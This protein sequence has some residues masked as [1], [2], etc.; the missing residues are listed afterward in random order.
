MKIEFENDKEKECFKHILFDWLMHNGDFDTLGCEPACRDETSP[1]CDWCI[2]H[3][4]DWQLDDYNK[5][6]FWVFGGED[7]L[8]QCGIDKFLEQRDKN[9]S[10]T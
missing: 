8:M 9:D 2:Q 5:I 6:M 1:G 10:N 3:N 4:I 7:W